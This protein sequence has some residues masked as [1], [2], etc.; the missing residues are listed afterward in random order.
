MA[1][2]SLKQIKKGFEIE[3][4]S[5]GEADSDE[6]TSSPHRNSNK[7]YI[8]SGGYND[9]ESRGRHNGP[10]TLGDMRALALL[11]LKH[12]ELDTLGDHRLGDFIEE[13]VCIPRLFRNCTLIS[14]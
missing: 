14:R 6:L 4:P 2:S 9:S 13:N 3:Q 12:P 10:Y 8:N 1:E 5:D 11:L 7:P